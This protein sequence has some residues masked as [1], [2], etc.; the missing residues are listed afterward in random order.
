[1]GDVRLVVAEAHGTDEALEL[2]R[3]AREALADKGGFGDHP[4]P[5]L[6]LALSGLD[7]LERLVLCDAA[8]LGQRHRVAR[9]LVLSALLDGRGERLCVLLA[10][11]VEQIGGERLVGVGGGGGLLDV[12]FLVRLERPFSSGSFRC[13]ASC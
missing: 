8:H 11:A 2:G 4:L 5:S 9:R 10:L 6:L 12:A 7:H 13:D 3:L 1:M